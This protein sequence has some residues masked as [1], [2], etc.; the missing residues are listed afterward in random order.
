ME[1]KINPIVEFICKLYNVGDIADAKSPYPV[2]VWEPARSVSIVVNMVPDN[3]GIYCIPPNENCYQPKQPYKNMPVDL[4]CVSIQTISLRYV[5]NDSRTESYYLRHNF[6]PISSKE[7]HAQKVKAAKAANKIPDICFEITPGM[8]SVMREILV[9]EDPNHLELQ[10]S[11]INTFMMVNDEETLMRGIHKL[12]LSLCEAGGLPKIGTTYNE[13]GNSQPLDIDYYVL[14]P[15]DH[16]LAWQLRCDDVLRK[17]E[18]IYAIDI[19]VQPKNSDKSNIQFYLVANKSFDLLKKQCQTQFMN[20]V[21]KR[22]LSSLKFR[23]FDTR[24]QPIPNPDVKLTIAVTFIAYPKIK[25]YPVFNPTLDPKFLS[26]GRT[27]FLKKQAKLHL[28]E[29]KRIEKKLNKR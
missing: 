28:E 23:L 21:D 26:F 22:P 3:D 24:G 1:E 19:N 13:D 15:H 2:N 18:G 4:D 27:L 6:V 10:T 11:F 12:E 25:P 5:K 7:F 17:T 16:I 14:V 9:Q 8:D 29:E 20:K